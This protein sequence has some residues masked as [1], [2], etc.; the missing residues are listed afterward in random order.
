VADDFF[1]LQ[2]K[3]PKND[4]GNINLFV[5]SMLPY[6]ATH[7][8]CRFFSLLLITCA[9]SLLLSNSDHMID[10]SHSDQGI[11]KIAKTLGIDFAPAVVSSFTTLHPII[12]I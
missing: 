6:G 3:I 11:A 12:E 1:S 2:G 9:K 4:F 5:K 10:L 8:P 7:L